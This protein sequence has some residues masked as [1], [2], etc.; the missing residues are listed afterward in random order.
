[1]VSYWALGIPLPGMMFIMTSSHGWLMGWYSLAASAGRPSWRN[2]MK[3]HGQ[4]TSLSG[5]HHLEDSLRFYHLMST[6]THQIERGVSQYGLYTFWM[7]AK[8]KEKYG[9][10]L[11]NQWINQWIHHSELQSPTHTS[12]RP[13]LAADLPGPI[14]RL[15]APASATRWTVCCSLV[16]L[17]QDP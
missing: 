12:N 3:K 13:P 6:Q 9:T 5:K 14:L 17:R 15:S 10:T 11:I 2:K 1:M 8:W 4:P 7:A 16:E